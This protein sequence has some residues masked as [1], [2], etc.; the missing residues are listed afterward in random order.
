MNI[1]LV[2]G[3]KTL[4]VSE[5]QAIEILHVQKESGHLSNWQL[6]EDYTLIDGKLN[7]RANTKTVQ[8]SSRKKNN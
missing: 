5:K 4:T 2:C 6:P 3:E 7:K 1:T 8:R